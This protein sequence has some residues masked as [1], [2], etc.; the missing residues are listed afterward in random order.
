MS[1]ATQFVAEDCSRRLTRAV[2]I[3]AG[4]LARLLAQLSPRPDELASQSQAFLCSSYEAVARGMPPESW[5]GQVLEPTAEGADHPIDL[6]VRRFGLSNTDVELLL[7]AG[8]SDE[9]E[10]YSAVLR[11]LHPRGESRASVGLAAQL[12]FAEAGGRPKLRAIVQQGTLFRRGILRLSGDVPLFDCS[13]LLAEGLW[14]ALHGIEAWPS[15]MTPFEARGHPHGLERWL[16]GVPA[17]RAM[18]ALRCN[19]PCT[20][21]VTGEDPWGAFHRAIV[22]VAQAGRRPA[23]ISIPVPMDANWHRLLDIHTALRGAVPVLRLTPPEVPS[24]AEDTASLAW[25][26]PLVVAGAGSPGL[27]ARGRSLVSVPLEPLG[28]L[29][30]R[31]MWAATVPALVDSADQLASRYPL[32]PFRVAEAA[33]DLQ[34]IE[35]LEGRRPTAADVAASLRLRAHRSLNTG[36]KLI[37]PLASWEDLVLPPDLM[38]QLQEAVDRLLL[39]WRVLDDWG[40]LRNRSGARGVRLLFAGPPG[41]GK[42]LSAEVL[43]HALDADLLVVDVSR[44]VSKWIG[45]TEKN[46]A[47]VFDAAENSQAVLL[48]DEADALFAKRTEV[49]DAHDRYAN[50]ETAYLLQRLERFEGLAILATNQRQNIDAAFVRRLE[51]ILTF[52]E[53]DRQQRVALWKRHIP[54][55][56]PVDQD[57]NYLELATLYPVVGGVIRNATVAAAF[58]AAA[59]GMVLRK[60]HF[61]HAILREY[62]KAGKAFP[63]LPADMRT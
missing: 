44:V 54:G 11:S 52:S 27:F 1:R 22:L 4:R 5:T 20:V 45:E 46:L 12:L 18:E 51:F 34:L 59:D 37:R 23:P 10:G 16:A 9:H 47:A 53:P 25:S 32:E 30:R 50:L 26:G 14:S 58:R 7:L 33:W 24:A 57:L 21:A 35:A 6:L 63:G 17:Q 41:T 29:D 61:V 39:Q 62:E 55:G 49:S 36:A 28:L 15:E 40:F 38:A 31:Q 19:E 48:L 3:L 60:E 2:G 8:M 13:V 56:V 42:T 43:A